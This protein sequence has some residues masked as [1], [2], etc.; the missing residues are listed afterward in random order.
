MHKSKEVQKVMP[1]VRN[2]IMYVKLKVIASRTSGETRRGRGASG[3][4]Q[5]H[6]QWTYGSMDD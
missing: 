4:G 3:H 6:L 2:L 1:L 5:V